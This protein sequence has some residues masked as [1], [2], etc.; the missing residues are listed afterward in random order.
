MRRPFL[1]DTVADSNAAEIAA[2]RR[3]ERAA[4][5]AVFRRHAAMLERALIRLVGPDADAEDL[6]QETFAEAIAGFSRFRGD[7]AIGTWLYRIA[8]NVAHKQLRRPHRRRTVSLEVVPEVVLEVVPEALI[9]AM[10]DGDTRR[11]PDELAQRRQLVER[12]YAHLDALGPKKRIAFLLH[13]IDDRP[14]AEVAALMGATRAA[15][16]S[17]V[18]LARR[19]LLSRVRKDPGLRELVA[20]G[21]G[22]R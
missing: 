20:S 21:E 18:F 3:G 9:G 12:L 15:T 6:L 10:S 22:E 13:V 5:A 2:C 4:I 8:V 7:A 1:H 11:R 19:E 17:R 16:K 14:L